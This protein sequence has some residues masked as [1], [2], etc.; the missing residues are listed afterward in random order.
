MQE[1]QERQSECKR[2]LGMLNCSSKEWGPCNMQ[3]ILLEG[4]EASVVGSVV[5]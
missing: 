3:G 1:R 4:L 5:G 2:H